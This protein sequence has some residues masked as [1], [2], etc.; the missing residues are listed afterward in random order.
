MVEDGDLT[1]ALPKSLRSERM[2]LSKCNIIMDEVKKRGYRI[3]YSREDE[4]KCIINFI[5]EH[6]YRKAKE[7]FGEDDA[8]WISTSAVI[9]DKKRDYIEANLVAPLEKFCEL[10]LD[11]CCMDKNNICRVHIDPEYPR[12]GLEIKPA[13]IETFK[14]A[15]DDFINCSR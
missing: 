3:T 5:D 8:R 1:V 12:V 11:E 15:L 2:D 7:K 9:Y 4:D 13:S 6:L 10:Y 14:S